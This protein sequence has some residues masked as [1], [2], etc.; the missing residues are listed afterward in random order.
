LK[1][2]NNP[3]VLADYD[4]VRIGLDFNGP[5]NGARY[6]V[7]IVVE[8]HPAGLGDRGGNGIEAVKAT[9]IGDEPRSLRLEGFP[10]GSVHQLRMSVLALYLAH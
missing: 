7:F 4:T 5:P 1:L 3:A 10:D 2:G 6:R 8:A 9:G